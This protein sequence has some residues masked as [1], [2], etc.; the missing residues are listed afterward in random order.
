MVITGIVMVVEVVGGVLSNSIALLSD[1]GHMFTHLF[2]LGISYIAIFLA[3]LRPSY[4]YTFGLYRAEVIAS[5]VNGIFL[6]AVTA[7]IFMNR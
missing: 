5:L 1:A 3:R 6:F 4:H 7:L 2:A